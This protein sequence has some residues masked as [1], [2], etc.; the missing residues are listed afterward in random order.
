ML[1]A[2][3]NVVQ[4]CSICNSAPG[5]QKLKVYVPASEGSVYKDES[6]GLFEIYACIQ[7]VIDIPKDKDFSVNKGNRHDL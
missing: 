2:A 1:D 3:S 4:W 7:C 6:L 5:D